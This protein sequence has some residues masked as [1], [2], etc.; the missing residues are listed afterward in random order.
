L[1]D[2]VLR[3]TRISIVPWQYEERRVGDEEW[4]PGQEGGGC[5][6]EGLGHLGGL[7]SKL[8]S[9]RTG[10]LLPGIGRKNPRLGLQVRLCIPPTHP[11][12]LYAIL[13]RI[14]PS[15]RKN[16]NIRIL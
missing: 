1:R 9:K 14:D 8:A 13:C 10:C 7:E 15:S 12:P 11:I 16:I 4:V 3:H 6:R 2:R 5:Q